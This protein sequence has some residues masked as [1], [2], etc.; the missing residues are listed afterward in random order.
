MYC[1]TIQFPALSFCVPHSKPHEAREFNKHY[2]LR[3]DTKLGMGI[4]SIL[5]I[6]CACVACK[7]MLEKPWIP[8]IPSDEK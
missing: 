2:N 3:F 4:C 7:S 1:N 6:P 8:G 5:C